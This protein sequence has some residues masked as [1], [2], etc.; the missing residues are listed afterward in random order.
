MK[1]ENNT[2]RLITLVVI[3]LALITIITFSWYTIDKQNGNIYSKEKNGAPSK[4]IITN[5]KNTS[6]EKV[7]TNPTVPVPADTLPVTSEQKAGAQNTGWNETEKV[8]HISDNNYGISSN[9]LPLLPEY[10]D[11]EDNTG[12]SAFR[13]SGIDIL[14]VIKVAELMHMHD[15]AKQTKDKGSVFALPFNSQKFILSKT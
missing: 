8:L 12:A 9:L 4:P 14:I 5:Q 2:F 7:A 13:D 3:F 10:A 15:Y 11:H 6:E 1:N